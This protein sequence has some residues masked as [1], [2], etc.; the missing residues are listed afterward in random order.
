MRMINTLKT[1]SLATLL[2]AF[3]AASAWGSNQ[4]PGKGTVVKPARAT[5]TTGFFLEALYSRAL[6]ELGYTVSKA[7]DLSNPI[8]YQAVTY[9]DVDFWANGWFPIH[10]AQLPDNFDQHAKI[11]GYIVK[12]GA[13]QGYLASKDEVEKLGIKDLKDFKRPEVKKAF[14]ANGDGKADLVACPPGWGCEKVISHHMKVYDLED[15][16][17][18]IQAGY[19]AGMADAVGRARNGQPVFFYTWTPN[20]TVFTFKPGED[21]MWLNVPE[22]I[23]SPAQEGLED[24]LVASGVEGAVTDPI[25]LGFAL[26]DI[27]VV[28]N[29]G[30]LKNNPPAEKIFEVMSV[31]LE[32]IAN[33][34]YRMYQGEDSQRDIERHVDEW[35][36]DNQAKWDSWLEQARQAAD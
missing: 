29:K 14:D 2:V 24:V 34:N 6:E 16:V 1:V 21:V 30:F 11:A 9:G 26:N 25:K 7:R 22:I 36:A 31:S 3:F 28:A 27:V 5:W 20:W 12:A 15:H 33:Q 4:M 35:I 18:T 8:F 13:L 23:P 19:S 17:N 10:N 32:D